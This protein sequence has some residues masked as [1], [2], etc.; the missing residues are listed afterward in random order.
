MPLATIPGPH[1]FCF[2]GLVGC[3]L[4]EYAWAGMVR[5]PRAFRHDSLMDEQGW[6]YLGG[7]F[8][9]QREAT[10][11]T[12]DFKRANEGP[13]LIRNIPAVGRDQQKESSDPVRVLQ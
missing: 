10:F 7:D 3:W 12:P 8:W 6:H 11:G 1:L 13:M 5:S 4:V 9:E 2:R